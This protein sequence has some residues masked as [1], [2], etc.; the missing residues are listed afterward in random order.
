MT[1][2]WRKKIAIS[3]TLTLPVPNVGIENSLPFSLI[4]PGVIR[5][6][7]NSC[8]SACLLGAFRSPETFCPEAS[9]P[10]NVKT[11]MV[12]ISPQLLIADC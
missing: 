2:N 11:G 4:A 3:L 6:R 10:E 8:P 1:E 7:R 12:L 9:L 5:S